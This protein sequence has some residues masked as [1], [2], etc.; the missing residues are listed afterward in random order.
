MPHPST[1]PE[2]TLEDGPELY[3]EGDRTRLKRHPAFDQLLG[4]GACYAR[5]GCGH[6]AKLNLTRRAHTAAPIGAVARALR[7]RWCGF[8]SNPWIIVRMKP[9]PAKI[10]LPAKVPHR[11]SPQAVSFWERYKK[12][13]RGPEGAAD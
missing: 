7:C 1:L 13:S 11:D 2:L 10:L 4:L 6:V 8:K 5:C 3:L 12:A 9:R